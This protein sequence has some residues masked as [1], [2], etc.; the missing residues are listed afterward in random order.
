VTFGPGEPNET[1]INSAAGAAYVVRLEADGDLKWVRQTKANPYA[2]A[3]L[4]DGS[5]VVAGHFYG[6]VTFG[7]GEATETTLTAT[8]AFPSAT[9][10]AFV[11][12]YAAD[13]SFAW[14]RRTTG[15]SGEG[16]YGV[17]ALPDGSIHAAGTFGGTAT[18]WPG[19]PN[20]A[21]FNAGTAA[22]LFIARVAPDGSLAWVK[23][24]NCGTSPTFGELVCIADGSTWLTGAATSAQFAPGEPNQTTAPGPGFLARYAI[25]RRS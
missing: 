14:V 23:R 18:F 7:A 3:A 2:V 1:V 15:T 5:V 11:A 17:C 21:T 19:D 9:A 8:P 20:Q 6:T 16:A 4:A 13:G 22:D 12:R 25:E 10:D 24:V